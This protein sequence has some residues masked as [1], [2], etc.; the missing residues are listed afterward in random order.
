MILI[1]KHV[2]NS[3]MYQLACFHSTTRAFWHHKRQENPDWKWTD[4]GP[5]STFLDN[6]D[7]LPFIQ[8]LV[9]QGL[10]KLQETFPEFKDSVWQKHLSKISKV[11]F[12]NMPC[13][14]RILLFQKMSG[15]LS[16]NNECS[17]LIHVDLWS[18]NIM[19]NK[20][21]NFKLK[22]NVKNTLH[23]RVL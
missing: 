4:V 22:E 21:G 3:F 8:E 5:L 23:Q 2:L 7:E 14:M 12:S 6:L 1:F 9:P 17:S 13:H 16:E 10:Q 15:L 20:N 18:N 19:F 11:Q